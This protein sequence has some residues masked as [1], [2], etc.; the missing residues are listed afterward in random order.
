MIALPEIL[1]ALQKDWEI[2]APDIIS[3]AAILTQ[4]KK[5]VVQLLERGSDSFFQL[6]YRLDISERKL[7][8]VIH[9]SEDVAGSIA[10]LIYERQRDKIITRHLFHQAPPPDEDAALLL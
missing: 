9:Q 4:L 8:L 10:Q 3:E 5:R 2:A 1:S 6:M 7:D